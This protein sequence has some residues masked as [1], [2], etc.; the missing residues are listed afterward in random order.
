MSEA[1]TVRPR[2]AHN[3][4]SSSASSSHHKSSSGKSR[5]S[6][7]DSATEYDEMFEK[8]QY[9]S[10]DV[11]IRGITKSMVD[12]GEEEGKEGRSKSLVGWRMAQ[13]LRAFEK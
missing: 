13:R 11:P 5:S 2:A 10:G 7:K 6:R 1:S 4:S 9:G 12:G 8:V 3:S